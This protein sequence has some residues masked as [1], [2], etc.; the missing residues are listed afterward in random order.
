MKC[1]KRKRGKK[2]EVWKKNGSNLNIHCASQIKGGGERVEKYGHKHTCWME[3]DYMSVTA[4]ISAR[5]CTWLDC[6]F[7]LPGVGTFC[8]RSSLVADGKCIQDPP[9][10]SIH[11]QSQKQG[12]VVLHHWHV[13]FDNLRPILSCLNG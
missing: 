10:P 5:C 9:T 4:R 7:S 3:M 13:H 1:G 8:L 2:S 12:T 6:A 11:I